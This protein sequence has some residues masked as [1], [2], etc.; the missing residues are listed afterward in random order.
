M[1]NQKNKTCNSC[2]LENKNKCYWFVERNNESRPKDIPSDIFNKGCTKY[3]LN[4]R[5]IKESEL[6]LKLIDIFDGEVIGNK[7]KPIKKKTYYK[8]PRKKRVYQTKHNYTKR[9]DW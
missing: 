5:N 8:K 1:V 3:E 4:I 2:F 6:L 9:K 7:F